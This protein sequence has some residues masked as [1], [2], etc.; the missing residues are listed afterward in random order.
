MARIFSENEI[1]ATHSDRTPILVDIEESMRAIQISMEIK[2]S[3]ELKVAV[4]RLSLSYSDDARATCIPV[5][6]KVGNLSKDISVDNPLILHIKNSK[7]VYK[8][9]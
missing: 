5:E 6:E 7:C 9:F 2:K 4:S 1:W 8:M 3:E